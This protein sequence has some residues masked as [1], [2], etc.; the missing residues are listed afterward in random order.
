AKQ[1]KQR[2]ATA[3]KQSGE[4]LAAISVERAKLRKTLASQ[5]PDYAALS[6]PQPLAASDIQPLLSGDEA[7]VAFSV[8]DKESYV[9]ALTHDGAAWHNID[10]GH[11]ALDERVARFRGGLDPRMLSDERALA[12]S[13]IKRELFDL[14]AAHELYNALLGPVEVLIK[15]KRH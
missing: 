15:N 1:P 12:E 3:E 4:R 7:M 2:D 11:S 13:H 10:L 14:G 6:N 9:F 5:F 8:G